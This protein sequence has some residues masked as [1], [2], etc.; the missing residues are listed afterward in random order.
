MLIYRM[1]K[2][3]IFDRDG[4]LIH[5][6][7][8]LSK[9]SDVVFY[10]D[11]LP[12][13]KALAQRDVQLFI[14]TNQSGIGRG[15]FTEHIYQEV[16]NY[17]EEWLSLNGVVIQKTYYCPVHPV[18]GIGK[19]KCESHDRKPNPGMLEKVMADFNL[20]SHE[21]VMVGDSSVD[22][23]AAKRAGVQSVLVRN[24]RSALEYD[25]VPDYVGDNILD[26]VNQFIFSK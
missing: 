14:A 4:T 7:P 13:C 20:G 15:F 24:R 8:Y 11:V 9:V 22:I 19:Y 6:V 12:A 21:L 25:V 3:V 26:V 18:H 10:P 5:H 1:I 16:A 23:D 17:V 2:G